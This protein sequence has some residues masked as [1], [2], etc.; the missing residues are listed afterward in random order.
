ME[1]QENKRSYVKVSVGHDGLTVEDIR[2]EISP[3]GS[4]GSTVDKVVIRPYHGQ[5]QEVSVDVP[6]AGPGEFGWTVDGN[7]GLVDLG[8]AAEGTGFFLADGSIN[9]L[10]VTD[11]RTT[12]PEWSVNG[13]VTD[14]LD[15]DKTFSSKY[16]GWQPHVF[17]EGAGATA[18][19]PVASGFNTGTG[20][21]ESRTLGS[22]AGGHTL[23]SAE[24]GADLNLK[25]PTNISQGNYR[26]TLTITAVS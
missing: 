1:S 5:G 21:S 3:N 7:N 14:F 15:G 19:D 2:S 13:Q 26:A 12:G 10:T 8:E 4:V 9:P 11:T 17:A 6:Q 22:A 20:L 16:L 18:G 25:F 24:L 23:G